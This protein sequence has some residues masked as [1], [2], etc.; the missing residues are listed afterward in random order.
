MPPQLISV[1]TMKKRTPFT[2]PKKHQGRRAPGREILIANTLPWLAILAIAN[3]PLHA[4]QP[5]LLK[6]EFI[7]QS[8]PFP[9]CHA[10]TIAETRPGQLVAAWFGGAREGAPDV[11]IWLS[12]QASGRWTE[13][14]EVADGVQSPNRRLPCWNPVLFQPRSGPLLLFYKIGPRSGNWWGMLMTSVDGGQTWSKPR[15]LPEGIFGP[16]KNKPVQLANG[17]ILC[18]SADRDKGIR[19]HFE[20]TRDLGKTWQ[21][22]PPVNDTQ[23]MSATQPSILFHPDNR[24]Q[25]IGRTRQ[26]AIFQVWSAD[27]G[28][29]WGKMT[30]TSLPNP[31]SGTDAVTLRGGRQL[32]VYNPTTKG[33]SPLSLAVSSNGKAWHDVLTLED[34]PG[35][36]FSYPAVIQASDGQVHITYT[37]KRQRIKHVVIEPRSFQD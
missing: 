25:A 21:A 37:W 11:G 26:G 34:Q 24:L 3:S 22:T 2:A 19:V 27:G 30:L 32:L 4:A 7:F 17:D 20:P 14:L 33:R 36:E 29:T 6:S 8:A 31:N 5:G 1:T 23:G 13:P 9:A 10:S 16:I 15:R 12:R 18:P 28:A 35:I